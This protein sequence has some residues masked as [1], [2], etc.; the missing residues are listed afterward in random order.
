MLY[1]I[2]MHIA[3]IT[4]GKDHPVGIFLASITSAG[5]QTPEDSAG[6]LADMPQRHKDITVGI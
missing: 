3:K 6:D 1:T 4:I 5:G 2:R